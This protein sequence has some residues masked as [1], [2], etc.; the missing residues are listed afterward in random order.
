MEKKLKSKKLWANG[1][2]MKISRF[3][4]VSPIDFRYISADEEL[5][6]RVREYSN[7]DIFKKLGRV[8]PEIVTP[9][10]ILLEQSLLSLADENK[11]KQIP[12]RIDGRS[13][14]LINLEIN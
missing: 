11:G 10:I 14:E 4:F 7:L 12:K 9:R 3:D 13:C 8:I 1:F 6:H 5:S 2:E